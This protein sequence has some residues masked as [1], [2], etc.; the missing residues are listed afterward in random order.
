[1]TISSISTYLKNKEEIKAADVSKG[2]T[3][4]HSKQRPLIMD[5]VE[6]L[7]LICKEEKELDGDSISGCIICDKALRIYLC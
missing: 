5:E 7:L 1:M 3:T 2:V 6:K 4:V